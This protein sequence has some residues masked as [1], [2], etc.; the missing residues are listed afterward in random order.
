MATESFSHLT[1]LRVGGPIGHYHRLDRRSEAIEL[2]RKTWSSGDEW[3]VLGGGSNLVVTDEGFPGHVL[4]VNWKGKSRATQPDGS[5]LLSV[6]AGEDW[7]ELVSYTVAEGLRGLESLSGIPGSVGAS[8][9]QN[10]GAYGYEVSDVIESIDFLDYADRQ[11]KT[12]AVDHLE[13][14]HRTSALKTGTLRGL[15]L[16]VTFR[17]QPSET[18][19]PIAY[20]QVADALG[21][22]LGTEVPLSTVRNTVLSLRASKG[23]VLDPNDP[24]SRSVG[25][26]F[27]NP[28]V[29]ERFA[30]SL[31]PEAPKWLLDDTPE[32]I[33]ALDGDGVALGQ[34]DLADGGLNLSQPQV[35][36][37][38][39]WLIEHS[40]I[41]KGFS[42]PGNSARVSTKHTLAITNPDGATASDVEALA[43]YIYIQV[44][45]TWGVMLEP[46]PQLIGITLD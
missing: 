28:V 9:I 44:A 32:T 37:S 12:L 29:S 3:L 23:M 26:F 22:E 34:T 43:R 7:D 45:N 4:H 20:Q 11:D 25:S 42:L 33:V 19:R 46:E 15:V 41:P 21:V 17:L 1:T 6:A 36:L 16:S 24:D 38:A 27:I 13:L 10:I 39:A 40:G 35:K 2:A 5:V 8:V 30:H 31:P 18:S 14:G